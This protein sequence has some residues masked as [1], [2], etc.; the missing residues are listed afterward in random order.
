MKPYKIIG[1]PQ[2]LVELKPLEFYNLRVCLSWRK[3]HEQKKKKE[4]EIRHMGL[5]SFL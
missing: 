3:L 2:M 5:I 4:R 1:G